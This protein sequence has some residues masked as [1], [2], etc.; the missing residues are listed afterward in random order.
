MSR[1]LSAR[2]TLE[3]LKKEAKRWL[4]TL[5]TGDGNAHRRLLAATPAAP[6]E[7]GLRDVQLALA[8]EYGFAGWAALCQALE[9]ARHSYAER[10]ELVLR[11][12][13]WA[14][15]H[16]TGA[17][18][19]A[20]WPEIGRDSIH[21]AAA[22]GNVAEVER[23]L[24]ADPIAANRKGGPLGREPL[25]YLAYSNLPGSETRSVEIAV[26]LLDHGA[27]PNACWIGPWG[28]PAFTVLTGVIGQGEG[29]QPQHPQAKD[30]ATLLIERGTDP[31][32]PQALYNTSIT[33]DDTDWLDFLWTQSERHRRLDGWRV[34][35]E[36]PIIGGTVALNALDYLLGNATAF[37]HLRRAE[38]LL[39]H[40]ADPNSL[41][42][43]SQRPQ[44]EEALIH[45]HVEMVALLQRFGAEATTLQGLSAFRAACMSLDREASRAIATSHPEYLR[46]PEPMLT[47]ARAGR[48]DA[49]ALLLE[50]GVD[51]DV[52]DEIE[53]R[54]LQVAVAGGS[55][56][57]VKLLVAHGAD[58][59]RPTT[60][61]G[62]GAMG[63]AAHFDRREIATFL[64][65]LSRDVHNLTCLGFRNRLAELFAED[66]D[67]VNAGHTRMGCTPLFFLPADEAQA[68]EMAAFLLDHGADPSIRASTDGLTAEENLR[69]HG[70]IELADFLAN[71]HPKGNRGT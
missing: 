38:W 50:L 32:D 18:L 1:K 45:G 5:Q 60:S 70:L 39:A 24:T 25:L 67:L 65:P 63:Y 3:T 43:Y 9:D 69:K 36:T 4:K 40:G 27:D 57:V 52:A 7:P 6:A 44:R 33:R 71:R 64:A 19:L 13:D 66:P 54:G 23:R 31:F 48:A 37:N 68:M 20:R 29:D 58:I 2:S 42:A 28:E 53:Q 15:D 26:R 59:D 35:S 14:G 51:V 46:D 41:H 55:L 49:V 30:L 17:R 61:F 11:S 10:V 62:G 12:A 22:T 56:E 21:T 34:A 47:A 8:R 16:A